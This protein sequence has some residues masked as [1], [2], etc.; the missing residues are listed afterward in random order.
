MCSHMVPWWPHL[1][2]FYICNNIPLIL[3]LSCPASLQDAVI[4]CSQLFQTQWLSLVQLLYLQFQQATLPVWSACF[5]ALCCLLQHKGRVSGSTFTL[6]VFPESGVVWFL[7][8]YIFLWVEV[9]QKSFMVEFRRLGRE[10]RTLHLIIYFFFYK[11]SSTS[12][13]FC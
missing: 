9:D 4:F 12:Y 6:S 11:S 1:S 8:G 2:C 3:T 13:Q 5:L 10:L 7:I